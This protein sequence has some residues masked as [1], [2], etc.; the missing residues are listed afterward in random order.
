MAAPAT[1]EPTVTTNDSEVVQALYNRFGRNTF[2]LQ[3]TRDGMPTLWVPRD[4]LLEVL[5]FLKELPRPYVMLY[6]LSAMD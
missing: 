6:D 5:R 4:Q 3:P 2:V 1:A